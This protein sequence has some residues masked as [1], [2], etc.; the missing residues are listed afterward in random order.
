MQV[1]HVLERLGWRE[2]VRARA[3]DDGSIYSIQV[4]AD[5]IARGWSQGYAGSTTIY[6]RVYPTEEQVRQAMEEFDFGL[7][8]NDLEFF[9]YTESLEIAPDRELIVRSDGRDGL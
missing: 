1:G 6:Y 4:D 9:D 3:M 2:L 5:L 7:D 8:P